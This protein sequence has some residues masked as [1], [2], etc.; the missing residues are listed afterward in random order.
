MAPAIRWSADTTL[1]QLPADFHRAKQAPDTHAYI[2][3]REIAHRKPGF[4]LQ[5]RQQLFRQG[6][7]LRPALCQLTALAL[8]YHIHDDSGSA[9]RCH[10]HLLQSN[11][12]QS[13]PRICGIRQAFPCRT[14][15]CCSLVYQPILPLVLLRHSFPAT[16]S[17]ATCFRFLRQLPD[18]PAG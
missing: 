12:A 8:R 15:L 3:F 5:D 18:V 11:H 2:H 14:F 7:N 4:H 1:V 9:P 13:L 17:H 10:G 6:R 16:A